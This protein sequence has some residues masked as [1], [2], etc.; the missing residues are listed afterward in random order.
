MKTALLREHEGSLPSA[1]VP[2]NAAATAG[3]P[4]T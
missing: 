1:V 3:L 4:D 2:F